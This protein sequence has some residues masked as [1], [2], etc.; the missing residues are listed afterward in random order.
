MQEAP[1]AAQDLGA[2]HVR[3]MRIAAVVAVSM[4]ESVHPHPL[5]H[6]S[7]K[8]HRTENPRKQGDH[9]ACLEGA[10]REESMKPDC[11]AER[12]HHVH[13]GG[14]REQWPTEPLLPGVM[15]S[16]AKGQKWKQI[17]GE[18]AD[19]QTP[20]N[21]PRLP[22]VVVLIAADSPDRARGTIP[23]RLDRG[24]SSRRPSRGGLA[25]A[26]HVMRFLEERSW[27]RVRRAGPPRTPTGQQ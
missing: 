19:Q 21:R 3:R 18:V 10:M 9:G 6:G 24:G 2:E 20:G 11:D 14:D 8:G 1:Q 26:F 25:D 16:R 13:D 12:R 22:I 27:M 15:D 4:V 7:L 23:R 5:D 17:A